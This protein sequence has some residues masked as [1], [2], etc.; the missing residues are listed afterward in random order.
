MLGCGTCVGG[1]VEGRQ[2]RGE[3]GGNEEIKEN[4]NEEKENNEEGIV[5]IDWEG[6]EG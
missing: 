3:K 1:M 5:D 2:E 6:E 4:K